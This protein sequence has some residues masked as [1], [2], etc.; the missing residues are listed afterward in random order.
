MIRAFKK[1]FI[2]YFL[3]RSNKY[4]TYS[5]TYVLQPPEDVYHTPPS[6]EYDYTNEDSVGNEHT[7]G[8][9]LG[10]QTSR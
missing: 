1:F 9:Q 8:G 5:Q 4:C 10:P 6:R 2:S 7:H 3:Y